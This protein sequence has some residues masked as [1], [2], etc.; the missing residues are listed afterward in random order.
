MTYRAAILGCGGISRAHSWGYE[1]AGIPIAAAADIARENADRL[2]QEFNIPHT[3]S[4]Y[5][6][7]LEEVR[8]EIVSICT[9]P[10]LHEEMALAA[11]ESGARG[12]AC[13]KPLALS[14]ESADRIINACRERGVALII[15]H[16]R[17]YEEPWLAARAK[18]ASGEIGTPE[19]V[20]LSQGGDL[21]S[22]VVHGLDL[23]FFIL[24]E[25]Q[26]EWVIGQIHRD[27]AEG[28]P[29]SGAG[30][31][32]G[33]KVEE[34]G[35]RYGHPVE[36][37]A[38]VDVGLDSGVRVVAESGRIKSAKGY[39]QITVIGSDGFLR[40]TPEGALT[41]VNGSGVQSASFDPHQTRSSYG[42]AF[43]DLARLIDGEIDDHRMDAKYHRKS[44]EIVMA[45][46]ESARRRGLVRLPLEIGDSPLLR[47]V[48][49]GEV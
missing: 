4:D 25:S 3:Y 9:W 15:G 19:R 32:P 31:L 24:G 11:V 16:Q 14:L 29:E 6:R 10:P 8:P 21:Q 35:W 27:K 13:E 36:H 20:V 17:R 39:F 7:L 41:V 37:I 33:T 48:E 2:A 18:L 42:A 49:A 46:Y 26:A 23:V 5:R 44:L 34:G 12:I 22:D 43:R 47:M 45:A 1:R 28:V 38:I 30:G 40:A